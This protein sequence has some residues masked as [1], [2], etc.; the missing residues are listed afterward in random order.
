MKT[1]WVI[2]EEVDLGYH[3]V[4]GFASEDKAKAECI[5]MCEQEKADLVK[6]FVQGGQT[7]EYAENWVKHYESD[8]Y[9]VQSVGVEQ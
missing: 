4:K 6:R 7:Q 5:R 9:L 1:V 8:K 3:M 2:C